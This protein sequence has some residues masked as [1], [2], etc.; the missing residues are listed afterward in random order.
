[1]GHFCKE[2]WRDLSKEEL[3]EVIMSMYLAR[4]HSSDIIALSIISVGSFS[5]FI[6]LSSV[7]FA[8]S[9]LK[10]YGSVESCWGDFGYLSGGPHSLDMHS[11]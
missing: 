2:L 9:K 5:C 4:F 10:V 1:M 7:D 3:H 11:G 6:S 8:K